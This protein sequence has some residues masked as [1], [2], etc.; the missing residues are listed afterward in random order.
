MYQEF[1]ELLIQREAAMGEVY[2]EA[3][4]A[5]SQWKVDK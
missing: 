4:G 3:D 5:A 1:K 2:V